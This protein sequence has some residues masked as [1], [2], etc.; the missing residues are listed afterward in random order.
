MMI[1]K[2]CGRELVRSRNRWQHK[3][4]ENNLFFCGNPQS[5]IR[6]N[7]VKYCPDYKE[8]ELNKESYESSICQD[9]V[10]NN[11]NGGR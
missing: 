9:V 8:Y 6:Y 4:F 7:K 10:C 11:K 1:C 3:G 2:N 5:E